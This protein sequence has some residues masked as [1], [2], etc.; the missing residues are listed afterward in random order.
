MSSQTF[1]V[2]TWASPWISYMGSNFP[3]TCWPRVLPHPLNA[4][5]GTRVP[6]HQSLGKCQHWRHRLRKRSSCRSLR[7]NRRGKKKM[8]RGWDGQRVS[9]ATMRKWARKDRKRAHKIW[10]P[11]AMD[12]LWQSCS[13]RRRRRRMQGKAAR[14][15]LWGTRQLLKQCES[16]VF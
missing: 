7:R 5:E 10:Q 2:Y 4:G 15:S 11:E 14:P 13:G 9:V 1:Y 6:R 3:E 8:A 12:E 16:I